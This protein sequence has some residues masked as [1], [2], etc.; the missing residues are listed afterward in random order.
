[1]PKKQTLGPGGKGGRAVALCPGDL[2]INLFG[3]GKGIIDINAQV[4]NHALDFRVS[5]KQLYGAQ[6]ARLL[7]DESRFRPP[8]PV[9]AVLGRIKPNASDPIRD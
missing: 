7:V 3:D 9:S 5:A 4:A 2:D 1:M 6:I 8:Q